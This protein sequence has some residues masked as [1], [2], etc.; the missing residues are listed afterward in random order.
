M[1]SGN[2]ETIEDRITIE[3]K[4]KDEILQERLKEYQKFVINKID[5]VIDYINGHLKNI[6]KIEDPN[7]VEELK[8]KYI[9]AINMKY[10]ASIF[11]EFKNIDYNEIKPF[12]EI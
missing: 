4:I 8:V 5:N 11:E 9:N 1:P 12:I 3:D 10:R 2:T 7:T 6:S